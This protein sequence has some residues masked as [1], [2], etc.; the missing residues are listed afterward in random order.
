MK[1]YYRIKA[2]VEIH[3]RLNPYLHTVT[4]HGPT[5]AAEICHRKVR[6]FELGGFGLARCS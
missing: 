1:L 4:E 2:Q 5:D 3:V 6:L